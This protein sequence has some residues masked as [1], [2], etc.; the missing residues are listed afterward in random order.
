IVAVIHD[1][2]D[3]YLCASRKGRFIS[4]QTSYRYAAASKILSR[5]SEHHTSSLRHRHD[6]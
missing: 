3:S 4:L 5:F 1:G 6:V 2:I